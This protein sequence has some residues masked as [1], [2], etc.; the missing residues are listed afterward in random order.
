[1]V[2]DKCNLNKLVDRETRNQYQI[3]VGNRFSA[4]EGLE[5]SS[6]DD[7][8]VKIREEPYSKAPTF[9]HGIHKYT[10]TSR[11]IR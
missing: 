3:D 5:V 2:A 4:L 11:T 10:W 6:V 7:T 1:M 9:A 8:W